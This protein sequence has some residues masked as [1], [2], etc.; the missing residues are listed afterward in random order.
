MVFENKL[1]NKI[2]EFEKFSSRI[3]FLIF[4]IFREIGGG[5]LKEELRRGTERGEIGRLMMV[6]RTTEKGGRKRNAIVLVGQGRG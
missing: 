3:V 1:S 5:G 4:Q 6:E 2:K